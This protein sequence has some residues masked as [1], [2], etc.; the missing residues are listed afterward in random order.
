[1]SVRSMTHVLLVALAPLMLTACVGVTFDPEERPFSK[2]VDD[3]NTR[4]ELNAKLLAEDPRLYTNVSTSV[5]EGRVHLSG[6][7]LTEDQRRRATQLA[8]STANV[9][10]VVNDIEVTEETS[11][12]V[13]TARDRW[14]SAKV[15]AR[16]L[17]DTSIR[18][19]NY[20]IDTQ[21]RVVFV[22][23]I[24]QDRGELERVLEHARAIEGV[25]R[26][27]NHAMLKDD[28]RRFAEPPGSYGHPS[29]REAPPDNDTPPSSTQ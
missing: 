17:A 21:N 8:W 13:A 29:D 22:M 6:M 15:R 19:V 9:K 16:I 23:G 7:V 5:I 20:T 3:F 26:V 12:L 14:I 11:G 1:M 10:E 4:T 24:A 25:E 28:P 18:D 27:V 2:A